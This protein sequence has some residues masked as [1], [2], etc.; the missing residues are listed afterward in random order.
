MEPFKNAKLQAI[1]NRGDRL[2]TPVIK[3]IALSSATCQL[4]LNNNKLL[5]ETYLGYR[6]TDAV[7]P[8]DIN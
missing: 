5:T 7:L 2:L 4:I 8:W 3:E 6:E 1:L